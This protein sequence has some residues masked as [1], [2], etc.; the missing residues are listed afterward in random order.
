[1]LDDPS[2]FSG[3]MEGFVS[4]EVMEDYNLEELKGIGAGGPSRKK[5]AKVAPQEVNL[6]IKYNAPINS[7]H[8]L[9]LKQLKKQPEKY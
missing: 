5:K 3:D 1:M 4:L 6:D 2:F 7:K 8:Q 9:Q